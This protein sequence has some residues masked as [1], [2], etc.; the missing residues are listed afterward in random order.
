[1]TT[2]SNSLVIEGP[3]VSLAGIQTKQ[4][5]IDPY[6]RLILD[7]EKKLTDSPHLVL[8]DTDLIFPGFV[9]IHIHAREDNSGKF[10]YKEDFRSM[11]Q[12]ALNGGVVAVMDMP[13]HHEPPI[14]LNSWRKKQMLIEHKAAVEV[15][16]YIGIGTETYPIH[17]HKLPYKVYMSPSIGELFFQTEEQLDIVLARYEE[18][19]ISFH[20]EDPEILKISANKS[21]HEQRRPAK[22]EISAI[23]TAIRLTKKYNL[24]TI[25]C[26]LST[27]QGLQ[28]CLQAKADG[29]DIKVEVTP[30]HLYFDTESVNNEDLKMLQVN[31]PIRSKEDR[32]FL[33]AELKKGNIDFIATDHA[34]HSLSEKDAGASGITGLDTFSL[35]V[36][37]LI[38]KHNISPV[39]LYKMSCYNPGQFI[40][41]FS[42]HNFGKLEMG[43]YGLINI[44]YGNQDKQLT[45]DDLYTKNR[46]S[47]FLDKH[48]STINQIYPQ[49]D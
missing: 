16:P 8:S 17:G 12:A 35:V 32:Y 29:L 13:N 5:A 11:S 14:D 44:I 46:W 45:T 23:K 6:S 9:D 19:H 49:F 39:T 15:I 4:V 40:N 3:C 28:L 34:P 27:K 22:A 43:Y 31:P 42:K 1:M 20:C 36:G 48:F 25:I 41:P 33:L 24:H 38:D 18:K 7:V 37:D 2:S 47:P 26:H 10:N 21:T 30:H